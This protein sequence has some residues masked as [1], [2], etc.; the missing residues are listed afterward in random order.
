MSGIRQWELARLLG[1]T[2]S[3]VHKY[4]HGVI[5]EPRR[6]V[7]LAQIGGTS[8]EWVLTGRHWENG[9]TEQARLENGIL[10]TAC[11]LREIS[12]EGRAQIDEALRIFREAVRQVESHNGTPDGTPGS[13]PG[14]AEIARI[15]AALKDH[16]ADT[17]RLLESAWRIQRAVLSQVA[18]DARERLKEGAE[19]R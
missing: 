17:L 8:I 11:R 4:E 9:S 2:Q 16:G 10:E 19:T 3:A 1:T 13:T 18:D 14:E 12:H 6:L 5:P 7:E 15:A